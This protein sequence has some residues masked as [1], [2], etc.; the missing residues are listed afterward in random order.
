[1]KKHPVGLSDDKD[2]FKVVA[3][4]RLKVKKVLLLLSRALR[5]KTV[6]GNFRPAQL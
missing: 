1:M 6:E 4:A 2:H 5:G 3:D